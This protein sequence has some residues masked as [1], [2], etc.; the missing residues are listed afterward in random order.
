MKFYDINFSYIDNEDFNENFVPDTEQV[1][2]KIIQKGLNK[3][4]HLYT[5]SHGKSR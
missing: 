5:I 2:G 1:G 3:P 4:G